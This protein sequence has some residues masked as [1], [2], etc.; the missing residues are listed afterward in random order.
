MCVP[1]PIKRRDLFYFRLVSSVLPF[2]GAFNNTCDLR[3]DTTSDSSTHLSSTSLGL[4]FICAPETVVP[5]T[6]V[7]GKVTT[8][9]VVGVLVC[10]V[11]TLWFVRTKDV[12]QNFENG[13]DHHVD[14]EANAFS[15]DAA[16][17]DKQTT[18]TA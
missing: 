9:F 10:F 11:T 1:E 17:Y 5:D 6:V 7:G 3:K 13:T 14:R 16:Q 4:I 18:F 2:Q 12:P 8:F 15:L